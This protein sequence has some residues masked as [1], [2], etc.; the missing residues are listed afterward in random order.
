VLISGVFIHPIRLRT[1][2][3]HL[4]KR[5]HADM[6]ERRSNIEPSNKALRIQ[7]SSHGASERSENSQELVGRTNVQQDTPESFR[8]RRCL[9]LEPRRRN[10]V[11]Q[12]LRQDKSTGTLGP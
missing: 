8:K 9:C 12:I 5:P 2:D 10:S 6:L 3:A 1:V 11:P 4:G 7:T